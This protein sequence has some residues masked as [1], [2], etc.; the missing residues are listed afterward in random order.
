MTAIERWGEAL[1][2]N[3]EERAAA[4]WSFAYCFTLLAGYYVLRPVTSRT[5]RGAAI[6]IAIAETRQ[7]PM[8]SRKASR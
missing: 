2:A 7:Q 4:L 5:L 6:Q 1:P 3:A 8:I